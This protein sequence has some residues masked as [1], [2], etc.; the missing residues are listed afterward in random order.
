MDM[1]N[2]SMLD[3]V[4]REVRGDAGKAEWEE[5]YEVMHG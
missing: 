5:R 4:G 3:Y 1:G 2:L